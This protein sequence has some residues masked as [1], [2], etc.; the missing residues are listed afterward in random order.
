MIV[1]AQVNRLQD[2]RRNFVCERCGMGSA[3]AP[4][5]T[6]R[7]TIS[8][9]STPIPL[10]KSSEKPGK[11][12]TTRGVDPSLQRASRRTP[13][14]PAHAPPIITS[15]QLKTPKSAV[16]ASSSSRTVLPSEE[17]GKSGGVGPTL[18]GASRETLQQRPHSVIQTAQPQTV[19]H[20]LTQA[21]DPPPSVLI[22]GPD[23]AKESIIFNNEVKKE[24]DVE[25]ERVF[26]HGD[27]IGCVKFNR[28]GR[29][30]AAGCADGKAY[31]YD[32]ES[33]TLTWYVFGM[34]PLGFLLICGSCPVFSEIC[35]QKMMV[36]TP[37]ASVTME[38]ISPPIHRTEKYM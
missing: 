7:T 20:T 5:K 33:G 36:F 38:S 12:G 27:T 6:L 21:P 24:L 9:S 2:I 14:G 23:S 34:V 4:P 16:S 11:S 18:Q 29:Y 19:S 8:I 3:S 1:E 22:V 28:D 35:L 25:M 10:S 30:L 32:V 17:P 37:S 26:F 13:Q 31:I 15:S